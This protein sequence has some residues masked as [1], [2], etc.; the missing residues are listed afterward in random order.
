LH[1][2]PQSLSET[3]VGQLPGH[4]LCLD[5]HISFPPAAGGIATWGLQVHGKK[6]CQEP[7][8]EANG[9]MATAAGALCTV[10]SKAITNHNKTLHTS[11]DK[12]IQ[13]TVSTVACCLHSFAP[14]DAASHCVHRC[15]PHHDSLPRC[16]R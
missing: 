5:A 11:T 8:L 9:R 13:K 12:M 7:L 14:N 4:T 3:Y 15:P 16:Q 6:G 10:P 1:R 2:S